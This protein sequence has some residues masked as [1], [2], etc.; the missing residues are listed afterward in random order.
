MNDP[1]G[2]QGVQRQIRVFLQAIA[3]GGAKPIEQW[4]SLVAQRRESSRVVAATRSALPNPSV[5]RR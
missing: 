2:R 3:T 4:N 5:K 1:A